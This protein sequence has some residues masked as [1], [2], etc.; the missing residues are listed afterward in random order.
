MGKLLDLFREV[1]SFLN[2]VFFKLNTQVWV[3]H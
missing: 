1:G 2:W 3:V